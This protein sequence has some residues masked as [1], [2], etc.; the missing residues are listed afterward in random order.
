MKSKWLVTKVV[1]D[2]TNH[3]QEK[4]VGDNTNHRKT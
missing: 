1:G 3:R 4:V 2:N